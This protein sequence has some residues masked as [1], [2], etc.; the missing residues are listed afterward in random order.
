MAWN[1]G[2]YLVCSSLL[3]YERALD[4]RT[5]SR[6][7]TST[8]TRFSH[9]KTASPKQRHL[10]GKR[11][12]VV[13]LVQRFTRFCK[14]VQL[15]CQNKLRTL[16]QIRHSVSVNKAQ[17][18]AI[19]IT[20]QLRAVFKWL[21]KVIT[22]LRLL[23]LVIGLQDSR[24]FFNQWDAKPKQIAPCR[25]DFSHASSGLHGIARNCDWFIPLPAPVVIGR[26]YCFGFGFSTVI[27]KPLY[28]A[29]KK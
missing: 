22:W 23:R 25:R 9:R 12:T 3:C 2:H 20:E 8:N 6:T 24:Q 14:K 7:R 13:I 29:N 26:S 10:A 4:S 15:S 19:R 18:P 28:T 11:D 16:L 21:S 17:L 27:W 1:R 5:L